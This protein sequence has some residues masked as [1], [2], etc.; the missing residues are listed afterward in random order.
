MKDDGRPRLNRD[1]KPMEP[2]VEWQFKITEGEQAGQI[3]GRITSLEPTTKNACG[4]LLSGLVGHVVRADEQ[5]DPAGYVGRRYQIVIGHSKESPEKTYVTQI[6]AVAGGGASAPP[7][8][9]PA[10]TGPRPPAAPPPPPADDAG[11]QPK[12][13]DVRSYWVQTEAGKPPELK[14]GAQISDWM[15]EN[16][17]DPKTVKVMTQDQSSGWKTADSFGIIG[18]LPF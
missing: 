2:G 5:I 11:A 12:D 4:T 17:R 15:I 3:V 14:S 16:G 9:P 10:P 1:G 7:S 13:W 8:A 6:H 18:K